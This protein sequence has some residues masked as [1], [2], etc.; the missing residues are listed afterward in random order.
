M[1][2]NIFVINIKEKILILLLILFSLLINQYY[3]NKGVF[4]IDSFS[5]FDTGFRILLGEY[6]FKDY[7]VISGPFVDYL[8][9]IFFYL[10]GVNWQAYVL[11]A[12]VIN[13]LV[14]L[15]TFFVLRNFNLNIYFSFFYSLS[16]AVLAYPSSGTPFVDHHSAF[17]SLMSMY[18]L[19]LGIKSENKFYWILLPIFFGFAFF[20][21]QVPSSY[22]ILFSIFI[23]LIYSTATRKI[24]WIKHSLLGSI[25]FILIL[26]IVGNLNAISFSSFLN[27]YILYPQT[28]GDER[29]DLL[30]IDFKNTIFHFKYI[31]LGIAI[32]FYINFKKIISDKNYIKNNNFYYFLII[33]FLMIS[34][35]LHQLL[36]RNQTFIFFLIPIL[37]GFSHISLKQSKMNSN[38]L[39]P[40]LIL[41]CLFTTAKYHFRFNEERKF[42][43][44]NYVDFDLSVKGSQIDKKFLGLNW[45]SPEY[46]N[47]PKEEI[48]SILNIKSYL[49]KDNRKKMLIT[50]YSF[51]SGILN[52]NF[53]SPIRWFVEN[54]VSHPLSDNQYFSEYRNFF[55]KIIKENKI[56]VIYT[57]KPV[58]AS[59]L[60]EI[61]GE[62][63]IRTSNVSKILDVHTV[64]NCA[65]K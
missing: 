47:N 32:F 49:E 6:P 40:L 31:Y 9:S 65:I 21:K 48:A 60:E 62:K 24:Y 37:I 63:C 13:I 42:H 30:N 38:I 15:A 61:L 18:L 59:F 35:I 7:W 58:H 43:E 1:K 56:E 57:I 45:I 16:L 8:Q 64:L 10:F 3:G 29:Y 53:Y 17:F 55:I 52:K 41:L 44:L 14:A 4:P 34:M 36:T 19:I 51:F 12:S 54:G 5:H 20:S 11:H 39:I 2:K 22:I 26:F 33:F 25:I 23:L 46:K 27:Q 50:N 28:L